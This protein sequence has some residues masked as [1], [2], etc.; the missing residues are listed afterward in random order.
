MTTD[1]VVLAIKLGANNTI[2]T[3]YAG[4]KM[5]SS[6]V[7]IKTIVT[8]TTDHMHKIVYAA[9]TRFGIMIFDGAAQDYSILMAFAPTGK[10]T[11]A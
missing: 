7:S 3:P 2:D 5:S 9:T 1:N 11:L 6:I 4:L 8:K 10:C